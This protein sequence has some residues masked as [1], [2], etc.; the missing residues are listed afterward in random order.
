MKEE[1][2]GQILLEWKMKLENI[3]MFYIFWKPILIALC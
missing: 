1:N 3:P 2:E